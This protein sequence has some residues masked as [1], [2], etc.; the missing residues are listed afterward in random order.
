MQMGKTV[1]ITG[2]SQ[3]IGAG[4]TNTCLSTCRLRL[5]SW[6]RSRSKYQRTRRYGIARLPRPVAFQR[7]VSVAV[8]PTTP[9]R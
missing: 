6:S 7:P 8:P 4:L 9:E 3:G 5:N 1:L 2:A